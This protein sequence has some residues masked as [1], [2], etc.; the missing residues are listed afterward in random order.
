MKVESIRDVKASLNR[1]VAE[2]PAEG[3][4]IITRNGKP[5]AVLMPVTSDTD[6]EIVA[7]SQNKRFW[8]MYDRAQQRGDQEGWVEL[9]G[10]ADDKPDQKR[11]GRSRAAGARRG[12]R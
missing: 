3:S 4:V 11:R 7:L 1:I 9:G 5:C 6:L 8:T 12:R 10:V 2:L